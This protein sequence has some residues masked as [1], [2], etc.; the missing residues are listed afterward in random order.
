MLLETEKN[1]EDEVTT[2]GIDNFNT[3]LKIN[4]KL[5]AP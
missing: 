1:V 5:C 4:I 2:T 3:C